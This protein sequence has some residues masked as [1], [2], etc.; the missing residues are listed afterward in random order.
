MYYKIS[1]IQIGKKKNHMPN[2]QTNWQQLWLQYAM[3][4]MNRCVVHL[5]LSWWHYLE[6]LWNHQLIGPSWGKAVIRDIPQEIYFPYQFYF[7]LLSQLYSQKLFF[8]INFFLLFVIYYYTIFIRYFLYLHFKFY[9]LSS[10]PFW[11]PPYPILPPP[12]H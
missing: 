5:I 10:F 6:R 2:I 12:S 3:P 9:P 4:P 7:L 11:K 8:V 1:C